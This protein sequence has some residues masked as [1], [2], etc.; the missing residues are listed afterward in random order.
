MLVKTLP[1]PPFVKLKGSVMR[2]PGDGWGLK[3][4]FVLGLCRNPGGRANPL[5]FLFRLGR[6]WAFARFG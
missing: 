3:L 4:G 1:P 2:V 6:G 5:F